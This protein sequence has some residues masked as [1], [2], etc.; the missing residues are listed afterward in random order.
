[1]KI[2]S[3]P[4]NRPPYNFSPIGKVTLFKPSIDLLV[5]T[6]AYFIE[7]DKLEKDKPEPPVMIYFPD[8]NEKVRK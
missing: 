4:K 6:H 7:K 2:A 8:E 5:K 3:S 1:M